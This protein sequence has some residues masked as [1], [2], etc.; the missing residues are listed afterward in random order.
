MTLELLLSIGALS[1]LDMLSPATLGVTVY[2]LLSERDRLIPRLFIYLLT[3]AGFYFLVGAALMLGLDAVLP[4]VTGIFQ[5]RTVSWIMT[6]VGG[7]LFIASFF[8][9]TKKTSEPRRPRSK[10]F[11]AMIGLGFTTS[12]LEVATALPYFAAIGLMTT[13]QLTTVQWMPILAAYNIVMVLPPILLLGLHLVFGRMMQRPLEKLRLKIS[14]SSGSI[15][16]WVLCIAGLIL[17]L[18]SIDNL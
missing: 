7:V 3:V 12:L 2:L 9:P 6:V 16:S 13:A 4:S 18:N 11:G 8:I 5:N 17:V 14:Q 15:L 1:L 10:S